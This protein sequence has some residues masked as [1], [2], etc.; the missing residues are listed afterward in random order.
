MHC[1]PPRL[2]A[3]RYTKRLLAMRTGGQGGPGAAWSVRVEHLNRSRGPDETCCVGPAPCVP[4]LFSNAGAF[5]SGCVPKRVR[6]LRHTT[7][8]IGPERMRGAYPRL[9]GVPTRMPRSGT[10]S[11][12]V[13]GSSRVDCCT[14]SRQRSK[15]EAVRRVFGSARFHGGM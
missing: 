15:A 7:S 10:R 5:Q 6:S 14:N 2:T 12:S 4:L 13:T 3:A 11:L 1:G 9:C 8:R